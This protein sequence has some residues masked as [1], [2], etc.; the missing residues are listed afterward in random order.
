MAET[1]KLEIGSGSDQYP[2]YLPEDKDLKAIQEVLK[3]FE[4]GQSTLNKSYSYFGGRSLYE[5]IDDWTKRWNGFIPPMNPLLDATQ[6]QIFVNFTRNAIISYLSKVALAPVKA[7]IIPVNKK[8]G[9]VDQ[10]MGDILDDLNS[11]SLNEEN[12]DA[13]FLQSGLECAVKGTVIVYEGYA[14]N[15]QDTDIP[16]EF[17][18]TTGELKT[19]KGKRVIFDNCFQEVTQLEDF[20]ITNAFQADV[21]KQ[22]KII[23]RKITSHFEGEIEFSHYKNWEFVKPGAYSVSSNSS[24]FYRDMNFTELGKDQIEILRYYNRSKNRHIILINGVVMY[25]GPIPFKDGKYPFAKTINEPFANDFFWGNGHPGKY[26][27]EQDLINSFIN[28][29]ADKSF[30]SAMPTGLSSDL[31][32]LIEDDVIEIG[33]IR[34]VGDVN[35]WKWWESPPVN[36][37]EMGMFDKVLQLARDSANMGGGGGFSPKGGK[38]TQQ[39]ILLQ[40][41]GEQEKIA[42][43]LDFLEDLERDRTELRIN[44]ILQFYSIPKIEK[45]TGEKGDVVE[46]MLYRDVQLN[47]V[48][49]GAGSKGT[50]HIKLIDNDMISTPD[51]RKK[52]ADDLSVKEVM[53]HMKG[54]PT[55]ALAVSVDTFYDYNMSIQVVTNSSYRKN[56]ALDQA[57]RMEFANWRLPLAQMAPLNVMGL[58][59]WVEEAFDVDPDLFESPQNPGQP[60]EMPQNPAN[61]KQKVEMPDT[62]GGP[63]V[64][65]NNAPSSVQKTAMM[66]NK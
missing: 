24:T 66:G 21:Q 17:D 7:H 28:V 46:K 34:Q 49:L 40:Q 54:S 41:Q 43:N 8:T 19:E 20:F 9:M 62:K 59:K 48:Q 58:I 56:Q 47:N 32:D 39:Q 63:K 15:Y 18:A 2:T 1:S 44:H 57:R 27:G 61:P 55:Q 36:A 38:L 3:T 13:K 5:A 14:K 30:N 60:G 4:K 51:A 35:N 16:T 37:G 52:L 64:L 6:S 26:M 53:G 29:L 11:Y 42:F 10:K 22:P 33:K 25:D 65:K 45:I 31:D 12:A 50:R 23:W